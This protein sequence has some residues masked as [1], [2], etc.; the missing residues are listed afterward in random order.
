M[1]FSEISVHRPWLAIAL[2]AIICGLSFYGNLSERGDRNNKSARTKTDYEFTKKVSREFGPDGSDVLILITHKNDN[3]DLFEKGTANSY[4]SL[5]KTVRKIPAVSRAFS[6]DQIPSYGIGLLKLPLFPDIN[7]SDS[8]RKACRKRA[9]NH[10]IVAGNL[11]SADARTSLVPLSLKRTKNQKIGDVLNLIRIEATKALQ[12]SN[13]EA[14]LTGRVPIDI[15][16]REAMKTEKLR[17]QIIG[18]VLSAILALIFFRGLVMTLIVTLPPAVGVFWTIGMLG[19]THERLNSLSMVIMPIILTMIGFTNAAHIVFQFRRELNEGSSAK[20][21][22]AASMRKLGLPCMLSALTTAAGFASLTVA[23]ANMI[24]DF[25]RDCAVGTLITFMAVVLLL[26][27]LGLLPFKHKIQIDKKSSQLDSV[28]G[29]AFF[30]KFIGSVI[31]RSKWVV[32]VS[33][34]LTILFGWLTSTLKPDM[35]LLN[36]LPDKSES[37]EALIEADKSLGGI[38]AIR[39]VAEWKSDDSDPVPIIASIEAMIKEE[40]LLSQPLSIRGVLS[41]LPGL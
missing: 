14:K 22:M 28:P 36:Q 3:G 35:Y 6:F 15:A 21:S 23:E 10:P 8:K 16:R 9:L 17:F 25:G 26:P 29:K 41:S 38:Q 33:V 30:L 40:E 7:D 12:G 34:I 1:K 11:L 18:Y 39:I 20:E 5:L 4:K 19:F 31:K 37:G 2:F 27:L 13:L 24:S 32:T